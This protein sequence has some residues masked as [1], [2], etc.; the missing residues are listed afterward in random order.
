M[1]QVSE[2]LNLIR[3]CRQLPEIPTAVI[4]KSIFAMFAARLGSLNAIEQLRKSKALTEFIEASLPSADTLGRV[5]AQICPDTIRLVGRQIYA[6]MKR[7]KAL[8]PHEHGLIAVNIDGHESHATY[9]QK[10]DGCL[11]RKINKGTDKEKIQYHHRHVTAQLDFRNFS[12]LLDIEPQQPGE[13]EKAAAQRLLQRVLKDYPR[14][15][16]VVVVDA[17]YCGAPFINFVINSGKDIVVVAKDDRHELVKDAEAFLKDKPPSVVT[18]DSKIERRCW[19]MEGFESWPDV[20]KPLRIVK[21]VET[22]TVRRQLERETKR[23]TSS[24]M[25]ATTLPSIRA[26]TDTVVKI[27]H[28]RWRIENNG[29]RE[30]SNHWFSDHLYKHDPVALLNFWLMCMIVYNLFHCFYLRNLQVEVRTRCTMLHVARQ[31]QSGLYGAWA[32]HPP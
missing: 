25:W 26:N 7:N 3:D 1:F 24:W 15:F 18:S 30:M 22:K 19:D 21:T 10:C 20:T 14:A 23:D 6:Q 12:Y 8:E 4:A 31:V 29:F 13:G 27:G 16:D 32:P 9:M 2:S 11:E 5:F 28:R 17:L